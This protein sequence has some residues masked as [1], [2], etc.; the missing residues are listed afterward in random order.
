MLVRRL[1]RPMLSSIF[2]YGGFNSVRNPD[3]SVPAA[4]PFLDKLRGLLPQQAADLIPQ[5]PATAVRLNGAVQVVGGLM[6][7]TGKFPRVAALALA[8]SM[9]PTTLAGHAFWQEDD[10]AKRSQQQ[11]Q[12]IK[13]VSL[14]GGLLIAAADTGG[15]PS[16]AWRGRAAAHHAGEAVASALPSSSDNSETVASLKDTLSTVAD[17][18]R[19]HGQ[20]LAEVVK[21]QA[22]VVADAARVHGQHLAEV[23]KEQAPVVADAAREHGEALADA[24]REQA[25]VVAEAVRQRGG[26]FSRK[27]AEAARQARAQVS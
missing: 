7:A 27:A 25:P 21:E 19:V 16:L 2:I 11:L 14:I 18:A 8:G 4:E 5:D 20:H 10:P 9:V 26:E 12:F 6:L 3:R 1:A 24:A 15:K 23:V 17:A 22:P 13:N